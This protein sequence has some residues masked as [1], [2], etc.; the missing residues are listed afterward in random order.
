MNMDNPLI[1]E[2]ISINIRKINKNKSPLK[3]KIKINARSD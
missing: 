3:T 2:F 1:S